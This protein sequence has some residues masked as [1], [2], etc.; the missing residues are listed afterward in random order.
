M[1]V[2]PNGPRRGTVV[3]PPSKSHLHRLLI[4][5]FLA[6]DRACLAP[7][8]GDSDDIRATRRCLLALASP[9]P[10]PLLDAG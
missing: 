8:P 2:L 5:A 9:D 7:E 6:G 3:P 4:A 10:A 1:I